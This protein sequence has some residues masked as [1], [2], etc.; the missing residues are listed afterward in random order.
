MN[1][2]SA[3]S[4]TRENVILLGFG[5]GMTLNEVERFLT[6][7]LLEHGLNPKDPF[8]TVAWYCFKNGLDYHAFDDL[9]V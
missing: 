5:L 6:E 3:K 7:A 4:I 2:L 1:W 9:R 8:E